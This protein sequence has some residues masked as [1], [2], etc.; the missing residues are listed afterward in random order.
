MVVESKIDYIPKS[1]CDARNRQPYPVQDVWLHDTFTR[2]ST[3][4]VNCPIYIYILISFFASW[5]VRKYG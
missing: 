2:S 3:T 4:V 1:G 5:F